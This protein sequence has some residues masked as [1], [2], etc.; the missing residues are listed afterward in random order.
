MMH[1]GGEVM[2]EGEE[3]MNKGGVIVKG[4]SDV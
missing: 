1:L 3:V 2:C 4:W